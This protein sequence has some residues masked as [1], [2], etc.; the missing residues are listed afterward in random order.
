MIRKQ[1]YYNIIVH[2][3]S[4]FRYEIESK[5]S[6]GFIDDNIFAENIIKDLLNICFEWEL[7]NLNEE[8]NNYPGI[9]LGDNNKH[10]GVQVTSTKTSKK[11]TDSLNA[12]VQSKVYETYNEIYF[13]ILGKKQKSYSVEYSNYPLVDCSDEN[14]WDIDDLISWCKNYD[15]CKLSKICEVIQRELGYELVEK[16]DNITSIRMLFDLKNTLQNVFNTARRM[17][18]SP[19]CY[20]WYEGE[21]NTL[22]SHKDKVIELLDIKTYESCFDI[23]DSWMDLKKNYPVYNRLY[24]G[25]IISSYCENMIHY[26]VLLLYLDLSISQL[27]KGYT[28]YVDGVNVFIDCDSLLERLTAFGLDIEIIYNQFSIKKFTAYL[29]N[30]LLRKVKDIVV[31]FLKDSKYFKLTFIER[32]QAEGTTVIVI[33]DEKYFRSNVVEEIIASKEYLIISSNDTVLSELLNLNNNVYLYTVSFDNDIPVK[34]LPLFSVNRE[35]DKTYFS[36][37]FNYK[38]NERFH[39]SDIT[40]TQVRY[41]ISNANDKFSHQLRVDW[42]GDVYISN[43][44]GCEEIEDLK[45][46]WETWDAHNNYAGPFAASDSA[47]VEKTLHNLK[48]CWHRDRR[49]YIDYFY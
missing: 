26:E 45:F 16:K 23:F 5:N 36:E 17:V 6:C 24:G 32:L 46:R 38:E 49:G 29:E 8:S 31:L 4:S 30:L 2:E 42:S 22:R 9:D 39:I 13:F 27:R 14:I 48:E 33:D 35:I 7:K 40:L 11:I 21:I 47:Y 1:E 34:Y 18:D 41:L 28:D 15:K 10:I 19:K 44:V 3:L 20:E 25:S 43:I 12:I 37:C